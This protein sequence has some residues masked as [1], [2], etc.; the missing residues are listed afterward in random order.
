MNTLQAALAAALFVAMGF[1]AGTEASLSLSNESAASPIDS[2][3]KMVVLIDDMTRRTQHVHNPEL[4]AARKV[5]YTLHASL[6]SDDARG[7]ARFVHAY[8]Q[9]RLEKLMPPE[10]KSDA[11]DEI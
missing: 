11:G 8:A 4:R 7:L 3:E 5:L 2:T 10:P 6:L 1:V 9:H